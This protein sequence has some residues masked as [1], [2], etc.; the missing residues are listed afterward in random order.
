MSFAI[1]V[2]LAIPLI[3]C[4]ATLARLKVSAF[5]AEQ[6][7]SQDMQGYLPGIAAVAAGVVGLLIAMAIFTL[8]RLAIMGIGD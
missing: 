4:A 5:T 8:V 3:A 1:R 7:M 6:G 2:F